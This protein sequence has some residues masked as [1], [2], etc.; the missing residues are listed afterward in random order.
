MIEAAI[1]DMDG[2]L[3]DS[4]PYWREA[5]MRVMAGLGLTVSEERVV[6]TMGIRVD[7]VIDILYEQTPWDG[8]SQAEVV[9]RVLAEVTRLIRER[10]HPLPGIPGIIYAFRQKGL[11]IALATS[12]AERV[13]E[14]VLDKLDLHD[15]FEVT[16]SAEHEAYGK[17]HPAIYLTTAERLGVPPT[18]CLAIE[19]SFNGLLAAKAAKMKT[20]AVPEAALQNDP[21]FVIADLK[22]RQLSDFTPAHWAQLQ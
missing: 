17:P 8:P 14:A 4:E 7:E 9:E 22:L 19:D 1:F 10:G 16:C 15:A 21:R 3:L 12:S 13:I 20:I 6:A 11:R 2:V 5:L 18:R